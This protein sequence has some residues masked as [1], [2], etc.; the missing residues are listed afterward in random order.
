MPEINRLPPKPRSIGKAST[1]RFA[2]QEHDGRFK[3]IDVG[4]P[5]PVSHE[6][7]RITTEG[8]T[9]ANKELEEVLFLMAYRTVLSTLCILRG[10]CKALGQ[11]RREKGKHPKIVQQAT[12]VYALIER[13]M[14]YKRPYDGRFAGVRSYHMTHHLVSAQSHTRL[15]VSS[16]GPYATTNILPDK[17]ISRIVVSHAADES[18]ERQLETENRMTDLAEELSD[19]SNKKPFID[20]VTGTFDAYI[21]PADYEEWSEEDK[22]VLKKAAARKMN[23]FL[24][25]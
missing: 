13:L 19:G 24:G 17:G 23:E 21:A 11:L 15:A 5:F 7:M 18:R 1:W 25:S 16:V 10:L 12:E 22:D 14:E 6:N 20:L 9:G 2:C 8:A 4:I 3:P